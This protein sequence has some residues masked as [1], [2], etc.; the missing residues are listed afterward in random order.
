[1]AADD[2]FIPPDNDMPTKEHEDPSWEEETKEPGPIPAERAGTATIAST[3]DSRLAAIEDLV[4]SIVAPLEAK[5]AHLFA[6]LSHLLPPMK[7]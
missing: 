5:V 7:D 2:H 4:Q 1:M 3:D 6:G